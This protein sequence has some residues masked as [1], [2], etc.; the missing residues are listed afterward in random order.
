MY[1]IDYNAINHMLSVWEIKCQDAIGILDEVHLGYCYNLAMAKAMIAADATDHADHY[2]K[3]H[4]EFKLSE[5]ADLFCIEKAAAIQKLNSLP[6]CD[7]GLE[8]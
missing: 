1:R 3:Y 7:S 5:A 6:S 4:H 8:I 2:E